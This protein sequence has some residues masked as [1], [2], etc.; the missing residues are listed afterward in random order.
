M[1]KNSKF[2]KNF[3]AKAWSIKVFLFLQIIFQISSFSHV[4]MLT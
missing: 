3:E 4:G 2:L 1:D